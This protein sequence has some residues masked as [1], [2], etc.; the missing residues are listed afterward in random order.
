MMVRYLTKHNSENGSEAS[1]HLIDDPYAEILA[2]T[3]GAAT[4]S[5]SSW[6][7]SA[8]GGNTTS[9]E[10]REKKGQDKHAT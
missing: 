2:K 7:A 10:R 5:L 8:K 1:Y 4:I 6:G 9:Q 3:R